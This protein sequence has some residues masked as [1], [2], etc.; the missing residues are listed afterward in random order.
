MT[1][2]TISSFLSS[3]PVL[4]PLF[5]RVRVAS[6]SEAVAPK[7]SAKSIVEDFTIYQCQEQHSC[8]EARLTF[9]LRSSSSTIK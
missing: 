6:F 2:A 4:V 9:C 3:G 1:F 8:Q 7:H 5:T